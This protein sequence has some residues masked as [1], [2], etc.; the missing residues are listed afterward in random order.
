MHR[1][2]S[3]FHRQTAEATG[4]CS[5]IFQTAGCMR[6]NV[7]LCTKKIGLKSLISPLFAAMNEHC[8]VDIVLQ[9]YYTIILYFSF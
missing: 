6:T 2:M 3:V 5:L 9:Y 8:L 4:L 7:S 1:I